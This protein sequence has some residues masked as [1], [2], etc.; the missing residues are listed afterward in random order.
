[1]AAVKTAVQ[2]KAVLRPVLPAQPMPVSVVQ[3]LR[4]AAVTRNFS[5]EALS[6]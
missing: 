6:F 3:A 1:M 5:G 4:V 2:A